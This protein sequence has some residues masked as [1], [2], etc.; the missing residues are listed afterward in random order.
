[1]FQLEDPNLLTCSADCAG[2]E[3]LNSRMLGG[4]H[5]CEHG[6]LAGAQALCKALQRGACDHPLMQAP[7]SACRNTSEILAGLPS[8]KIS[9]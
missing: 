7:E 2:V 6:A 3:T 4:R 8:S 1:M 9:L 5:E